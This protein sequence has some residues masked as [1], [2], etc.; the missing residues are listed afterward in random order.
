MLKHLQVLTILAV[1]GIGG[2]LTLT[3][4]QVAQASSFWGN[5]GNKLDQSA[6]NYRQGSSDGE[7]EGKNDYPNFD[8]DCPRDTLTAYCTGYLVGYNRG[9]DAA[10]VFARNN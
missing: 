1:L 2:G 4:I 10:Q 7:R 6:D 8:P 5:L 3:Q 9:W